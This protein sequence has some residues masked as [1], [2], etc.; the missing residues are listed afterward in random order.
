MGQFYSR[1]FDGDPY[2][3]LMRSLPERELV[4]WAQK[5]IWLAE[6]FTF[7]G[8]FSRTYPRVFQHT[9]TRC[10]G[11]G[12]MTCPACSG[13]RQML[14]APD[15]SVDLGSRK[16]ALAAASGAGAGRFPFTS[17]GG[18]EGECRVCGE[19]CEWDA[20]SEWAD[21]WGE[22]EARLAYYDKSAGPLLDEWYEDVIHAGNLEEDTQQPEE[23]PPGPEVEGQ[24]AAD[25]RRLAKDKKRFAALMRRYGHPYDADANLG[26]QIVDPTATMGENIWNMAQV[27]NSVPPE[28][29]PFRLQHLIGRGG[30]AQG[31]LEVQ[32]AAMDALNHQVVK[33]A[34]I[35]SNLE[36]AAQGLPKPYRFGHTAGTVPCP[37]CDGA[38][39]HYSLIP[40]TNVLFRL[41]RPFWSDEL[42]RL[43]KYWNPTHLA[44]RAQTGQ[45]L[46]YGEHGLRSLL[47]AAGE[48]EGAGDDPLAALV[49]PAPK[50]TRRYAPDLEALALYPQ[51]RSARQRTEGR[52]GELAAAVEEAEAAAQQELDRDLA[53]SA[54]PLQLTPLPDGR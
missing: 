5:V 50:S 3:D 15:G 24:W 20:E 45:V 53:S 21:K 30:G 7:V 48:G 51:L 44:D 33:E 35:M 38:A 12:V 47:Q 32:E 8:H 46:P 25:E 36:A 41:E 11:A 18:Q 34:A 54:T 49:G 2:I 4:W 14:T 19:G 27:Y 23:E 43:S 39:W 16:P 31:V 42:Q 28:L 1:E 13:T 10:K 26:Y 9:C 37:E 6:G 52:L 29:N 17:A 40:N 22:W